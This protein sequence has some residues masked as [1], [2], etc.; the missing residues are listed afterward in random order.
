MTWIIISDFQAPPKDKYYQFTTDEV[1]PLSTDLYSTARHDS[2]STSALLVHLPL[3][4]L[5][6][7]IVISK[8]GKIEL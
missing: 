5:P 2:Y 1:A 7:D 6:A 3:T 8:I 4:Y